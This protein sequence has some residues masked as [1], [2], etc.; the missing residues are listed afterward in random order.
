MGLVISIGVFPI[1]FFFHDQSDKFLGPKAG[2]RQK[3][4]RRP[5]ASDDAPKRQQIQARD[6]AGHRKA[7]KRISSEE[8][9]SMLSSLDL[10]PTV[11]IS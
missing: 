7:N 1:W 9:M 6:Y 10:L 3:V 11:I 5:E 2:P 8:F 4:R